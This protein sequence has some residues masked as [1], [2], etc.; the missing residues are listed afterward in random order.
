MP[1]LMFVRGWREGEAVPV[2]APGIFIGRE[3]DNDLQLP[4]EGVSRY[5]AKLAEQDG[6]WVV[7]DMGSSNGLKVNNLRQE[8]CTLSD[9][10]LLTLGKVVLRF[11]ADPPCPSPPPPVPGTTAAPAGLAAPATPAEQHSRRQFNEREREIRKLMRG[12]IEVKQ[13]R[14]RRYALAAALLLN[15][16]LLAAYLYW[17]YLR[18]SR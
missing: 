9:G 14:L 7:S 10:D 1:K 4:V 17:Q 11:M 16:L 5:H 2:V 3:T 12:A 15:L 18:R 6:A 13:R 8:T